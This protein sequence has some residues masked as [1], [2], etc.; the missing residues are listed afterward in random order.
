MG[1]IETQK[2]IPVHQ[3]PDLA[4]LASDQSPSF[5]E[6]QAHHRINFYAIVWFS[7]T[8][9]THYIDFEPYPLKKDSV[10][11]LGKNQAHS[12]PGAALPAARAIVFSVDFFQAIEEPYL[13]QMFLPFQNEGI[14]IPP[15]MI[16]PLKNLFDLILLEY[17]SAADK[18]LLLKYTS[19]LLMHLYRF[20]KH[21]HPAFVQQ[22]K[23]VDKLLHL[24]EENY[25]AGYPAGFYAS[26]VGIS[27]KRL[28]EILKKKMGGTL[29]QLIQ[30]L[31]LVE[32]KRE[33][34][35][36][37]ESIKEIAYKLGFNEQSYFTRFFKKYTGNSPETFRTKTISASR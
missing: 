36:G 19:V 2:N 7:E 16:D 31:L 12:I 30:H 13:R 8:R 32:A 21:A 35:H 18:D 22:D 14:D 5:G 37:S 26:Q 23:R 33:L 1:R 25:K 17:K 15:G 27:T 28:N 24:L 9:G 34:A 29:S 6:H 10:Y 20:S 11:L 4:F 3:L